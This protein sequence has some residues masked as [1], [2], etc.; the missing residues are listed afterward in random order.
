MTGVMV[1]QLRRNPGHDA[2][3]ARPEPVPWARAPAAPRPS[4]ASATVQAG[5]LEELLA[6]HQDHDPEA[7]PAIY[8]SLHPRLV[9][10]FRAWTASRASAEDLAQTTLLRLHEVRHTYERGRPA[11]PWVWA[12]ARN[13][14][15]DEA[16][17]VSARLRQ[18]RTLAAEEPEPVPAPDE[19]FDGAGADQAVRD[20]IA[21]LPAA[22]RE[23]ILL[24]HF[25]GLS[26]REVASALGCT[27][28]AAKLRAHRGYETL[29]RL[30]RRDLETARR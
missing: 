20:A 2:T 17:R 30:L 14:R 21:A 27:V 3:G 8:A 1:A 29:R 7:F 13:V 18:K 26:L 15:T 23:V 19:R 4:R 28:M 12:I 6:R 5:T 22:H 10:F 25:E 9:R 11:G 24:H 16:R